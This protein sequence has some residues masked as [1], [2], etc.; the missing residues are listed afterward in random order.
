MQS[1]YIIMRVSFSRT[2][3]N[4]YCL[5]LQVYIQAGVIS[6]VS[7]GW[8]YHRNARQFR[9]NWENKTRRL[10]E[11]TETDAENLSVFIIR[12]V[13]RKIGPFNVI[14]YTIVRHLAVRNRCY[15]ANLSS[16]IVGVHGTIPGI[17]VQDLWKSMERRT[18]LYS[19]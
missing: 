9:S 18:F 3:F 12:L 16:D 4:I 1:K 11:F 15:H 17:H 6:N 7:N 19:M 13:T 2:N 5:T 8:S 10:N 14:G